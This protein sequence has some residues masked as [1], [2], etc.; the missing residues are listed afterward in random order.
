M[1]PTAERQC[2]SCVRIGHVRIV[3]ANTSEGRPRQ[4][5]ETADI[6]GL[7]L[8]KHR[9]LLPGSDSPYLIPGQNGGIRSKSCIEEVISSAFLKETGLIINP[10]LIRDIVGKIV[11]ERDPAAYGALTT[12]LGH[13]TDATTRAHYLGSETKAAGRYLDGIIRKATAANKA[14]VGRT[15]SGEPPR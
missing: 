14:S 7:Y 13:S 3:F 10:H 5:D 8:D 9:P 12:V 4:R 15:A 6:L 11:V 1:P 2:P